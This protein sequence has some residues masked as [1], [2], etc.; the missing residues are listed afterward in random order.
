MP[1]DNRC[2]APATFEVVGTA[3]NS[4][5]AC[6]RPRIKEQAALRSWALDVWE[7]EGGALA[8]RD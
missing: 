8:R 4:I 1:G 2:G 7:D 3:G 5:G 6:R